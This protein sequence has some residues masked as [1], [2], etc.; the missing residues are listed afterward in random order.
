MKL[1]APAQSH[2]LLR[3]SELRETVQRCAHCVERIPPSQRFGNNV[4]GAHKIPAG[5]HGSAGDD[6]GPFDGGLQEDVFAAKQAMDLVWN[7]SRLEWNMD[8]ILLC[9]LHS[10]RDGDR[11]FR[12]LALTDADPPLSVTHHDERAE[13]EALTA[14]DDFG[15]TVDEH[16]LILEAQFVWIDSH[17]RC[18]LLSYLELQSAFAGGI[19]QRLDPAV[20]QPA[21]AVKDDLLDLGILG[22]LGQERAHG[23]GRDDAAGGLQR[24]PQ[25]LVQRRGSRQR[26]A[27]EVVDDLRID[28][29]AA[30]IDIEPRTLIRSED[31]LT[32]TLLAPGEMR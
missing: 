22:A 27:L 30:A 11:Y 5:S 16:D 10:F 20:I 17:A 9:L 12:G 29:A 4:V 7:G 19:R 2:D 32:N 26:R 3:I 6:A 21:S 18:S 25:G 24:L 14:F 23:F 15:D 13:I 8:E 31:A 28:M 1:F